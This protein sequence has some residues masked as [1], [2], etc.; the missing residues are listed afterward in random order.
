MEI[1]GYLLM[2]YLNKQCKKNS[3]GQATIE[4]ALTILLV[5]AFTFF[6]LQLSMTMAF[7]NFAHYATFMAARAYQ[8]ASF[9]T[10]DQKDRA[11]QTLASMVK[12]S[13]TQTGIDRFP[14]IAKGIGGDGTM[15]GAYIGEGAEFDPENPDYSW[16]LGVR[17]TFKSRLFVL[18]LGRGASASDLT[19]TSESWLGREPTHEECKDYMGAKHAIWDNGC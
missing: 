4:F 15:N 5:M 1:L 13:T 8:A 18:P 14:G 3:S 12:K 10:E 9:S 2:Q 19:L 16:L 17:Y 6:F 11:L 7:G